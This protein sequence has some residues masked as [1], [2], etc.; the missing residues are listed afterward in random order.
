MLIDK[1]R[2]A[3]SRSIKISGKTPS[4]LQ[5]KETNINVLFNSFKSVSLICLTFGIGVY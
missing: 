3:I 5:D 4:L 2:P 1:S